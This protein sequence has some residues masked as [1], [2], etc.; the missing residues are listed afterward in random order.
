MFW[1]VAANVF[2]HFF[3]KDILF[4]LQECT[5]FS[6]KTLHMEKVG[7][8]IPSNLI[9]LPIRYAPDIVFLQEVVS[10]TSELITA[11]MPEY[12]LFLARHV[13][14]AHYFT[15]VM[16]KKS[17]VEFVSEEVRPFQGSNQGRAL[18]IVQ[19]GHGSILRPLIIM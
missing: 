14:M 12:K 7:I 11:R 5:S 17:S 9:S 13:R 10:P 8:F 3:L 1:R 18:H 6:L 4:I 19:V 15:V 2:G 16:L